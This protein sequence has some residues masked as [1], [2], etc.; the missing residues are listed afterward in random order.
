MNSLARRVSDATSN[1]SGV[2]PAPIS[3]C[4]ETVCFT[5]FCLPLPGSLV[6][7]VVSYLDI[8]ERCYGIISEHSSRTIKRD[9]IRRQRFVVDA[10]K[11]HRETRCLLTRQSGLEQSHH[12]LLLF[13]N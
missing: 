9:Q 3:G 4:P 10:H 6:V 1:Q 11:A 12:A 2:A 13:T 7:M 5:G 8:F